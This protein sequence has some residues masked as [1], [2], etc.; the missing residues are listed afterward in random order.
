MSPGVLLLLVLHGE[1]HMSCNVTSTKER[2]TSRWCSTRRFSM[3]PTSKETQLVKAASVSSEGCTPW[4]ICPTSY[5]KLLTSEEKLFRKAASV[6]SFSKAVPASNWCSRGLGGGSPSENFSNFHFQAV[7]KNIKVR[8][9]PARTCGQLTILSVLECLNK[10]SKL[11][12][13]VLKVM[14]Q[15]L[16]NQLHA[17]MPLGNIPSQ[18]LTPIRTKWHYLRQAPC[19]IGTYAWS[20]GQCSAWDREKCLKVRDWPS[21]EMNYLMVSSSSTWFRCPKCFSTGGRVVNVYLEAFLSPVA[22]F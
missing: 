6:I 17:K 4:R 20:D 1:M 15:C 10:H 5:E 13:C 11:W 19:V 9:R 14:S 22:A 16:N 2:P 8:L 12:P 21:T 7:V 3:R 18:H